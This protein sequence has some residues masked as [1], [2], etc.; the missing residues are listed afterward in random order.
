MLVVLV[1]ARIAGSMGVLRVFLVLGVR[2]KILGA[3]EL[4]GVN[5]EPDRDACDPRIMV[6]TA[7]CSSEGA[8]VVVGVPELERV[9]CGPELERVA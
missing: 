9:A 7:R 8:E 1:V 4:M 5:P 3:E 2:C 6:L